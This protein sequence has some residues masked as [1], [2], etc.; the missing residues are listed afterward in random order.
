MS[1]LNQIKEMQS[2]KGEGTSLITLQIPY[3]V[4]NL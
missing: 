4:S 1:H 3:G 2:A